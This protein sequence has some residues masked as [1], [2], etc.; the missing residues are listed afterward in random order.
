MNFLLLFNLGAFDFGDFGI[1]DLAEEILTC[2][3]HVI[4]SVKIHVHARMC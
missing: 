3:H 2:N 4:P 1:A